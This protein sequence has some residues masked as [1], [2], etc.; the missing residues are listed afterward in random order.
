MSPIVPLLKRVKSLIDYYNFSVNHPG[1][2]TA[3]GNDSDNE[4][5]KPEE[6]NRIFPHLGP[7][8]FQMNLGE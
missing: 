4:L 5:F 6:N 8:A 7:E 3:G 1:V 2:Y